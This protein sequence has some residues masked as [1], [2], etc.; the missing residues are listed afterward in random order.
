[1][2]MIITY[3]KSN[4]IQNVNNSP[5]E[6][7]FVWTTET[8]K[9][10]LKISL[11]DKID[12]S[13]KKR[14][15]TRKK[16]LKKGVKCKNKTQQQKSIKVKNCFASFIPENHDNTETVRSFTLLPS[17]NQ[18]DATTIAWPNLKTKRAT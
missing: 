17:Q 8:L 15:K 3:H 2:L 6:N 16:Q 12:N 13:I 18:A 7:R 1:M 9:S 4:Y 11:V 14:N 5:N 10:P